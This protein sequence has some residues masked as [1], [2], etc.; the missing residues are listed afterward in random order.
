M[1]RCLLGM[2]EIKPQRSH[3]TGLLHDKNIR[4][5]QILHRQGPR[6]VHHNLWCSELLHWSPKKWLCPEYCTTKSAEY[7]STK[8]A[9]YYSTKSAEYYSTKSAEYYS[10]KSAE[11][12]S[13][14]SA[15]NSYYV[16]PE[17]LT[18]AP[19]YFIT[20][21]AFSQILHH[22]GNRVLHH[23]LHY[24]HLLHRSSEVFF[25]PELLHH[26]GSRLLHL[27]LRFR[28]LLHGDS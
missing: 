10:T 16:E 20:T 15:D 17:Y 7:Y 8:S 19:V 1:Y 26:Q 2:A 11:Y 5:N 23:Y 25:C 28:N 9:E 6:V 27:K 21:F 13:T 24:H 22:Q 12:Y 18:D 14:K 4:N 3:L